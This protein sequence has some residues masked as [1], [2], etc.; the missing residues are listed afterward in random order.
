[1][2]S[3]SQHTGPANQSEP[4]VYF[5]G[6]GFIKPGSQQT[7]LGQ[8]KKRYRIKLKYVKNKFFFFFFFKQSLNTS[9]SAPHKHNQAFENSWSTTPLNEQN[10]PQHNSLVL[11]IFGPQNLHIAYMSNSMQMSTLPWKNKVFIK[12]TKPF[13]SCAFK[14]ALMCFKRNLKEIGLFTTYEGCTYG[15]ITFS[16]DCISCF[17]LR[18]QRLPIFFLCQQ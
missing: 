18:N 10:L 15:K 4:T 16:F 9:Y 3:E 8:Q 11:L 14:S 5:W 1:M 17:Q 6:R 12:R 7:V 2:V 13:L